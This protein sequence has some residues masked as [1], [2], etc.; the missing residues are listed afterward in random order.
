MSATPAA[1]WTLAFQTVIVSFASFL[2]WFWLLR[3]YL[4]SRLGVLSFMT[5]IF[6]VA[7]GALLLNEDLEPPFLG[8]AMLVLFGIVLVSGYEWYGKKTAA[9]PGRTA[10]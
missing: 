6:G 4:V 2:A 7:L 3:R 1:W 9:A 5:P 10:V 8:G